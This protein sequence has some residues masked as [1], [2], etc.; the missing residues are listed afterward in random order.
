MPIN[1][2]TKFREPSGRTGEWTLQRQT[3]FW[4][5]DAP[6]AVKF[7]TEKMC[8][9]LLYRDPNSPVH[10]TYICP[11]AGPYGEIFITLKLEAVFPER[12]LY[13]LHLA[14]TGS[15][16]WLDED[17]FLEKS[18]HTFNY[19]CSKLEVPTEEIPWDQ[20]S[21]ALLEKEIRDT[22]AAEAAANSVIVDA[23]PIEALQQKILAAVRSGS[24]Y[25]CGHKEG[26]ICFFFSGS[27][28]M[29]ID[30]GEDPQTIRFETDADFL[31][32]IWNFYNWDA[33]RDT[34]PHSPPDLD[35]WKFIESKLYR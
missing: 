16:N 18:L 10:P 31:K 29:R 24:R 34:Y 23:T 9:N 4:H 5:S 19:W 13:S 26:T 8:A 32:A 1:P 12:R 28:F 7:A 17:E 20:A 15:R 2:K 14:F 3:Y 25:Y 21:P 35:V 22:L 11:K 27:N 6:L 30:E 33:K